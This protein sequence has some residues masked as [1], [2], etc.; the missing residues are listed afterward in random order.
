METEREQERERER[1]RGEMR[2]KREEKIAV[3]SKH[4]P[5]FSMRRI[6]CLPTRRSAQPRALRVGG[7]CLSRGEQK[8]KRGWRRS[9]GQA[10][11]C[12]EGGGAHVAHLNPFC[13]SPLLSSSFSSSPLAPPHAHARA[14]ES[15][16]CAVPHARGSLEQKSCR[17]EC[18]SKKE[19]RGKKK[20]KKKRSRRVSERLR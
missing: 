18:G 7:A 5:R 10:R 4:R 9:T 12:Q 6:F 19:G 15:A 3:A 16:W 14:R 17:R 11:S 13:D 8:E 2:K 20:K 1:E